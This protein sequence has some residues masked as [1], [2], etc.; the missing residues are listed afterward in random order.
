MNTSE[1]FIEVLSLP[2]KDRAELVQRLLS[3]LEQTVMSPEIEAAWKEEAFERC[4]AFDQGEL[5]ERDA[6]DVIRDAR[7]KFA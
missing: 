7:A 4:K 5:R 6:D 3:S 1:L 2:V